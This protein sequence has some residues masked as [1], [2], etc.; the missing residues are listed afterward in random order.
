MTTNKDFKH[1][2]RAR[3]AKTGESYT[4]ARAVLLKRRHEG[5]RAGGQTASQSALVP[6]G[7]LAL[8]AGMSDAKVKQATGCDWSSW[9]KALDYAEA[10]NWPHGEIARYVKEKFK[11]P[12]WWTQTVTVGYER[13]KGLRQKGQRRDGG[14]EASKSVTLP[15]PVGKLYRAFNDKRARRGW[16]PGIDLAIRSKTRDKYMRIT[17]PD[18]TSVLVGFYAKGAGK[19][20]V[21]VQHVGLADQDAVLRSK[22]YWG[23]RFA[24]LKELLT[25]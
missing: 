11:T 14:F 22:G 23:E 19:S 1:L 13:I 15:V 17:W 7:P 12:D 9:A 25:H 6:S 2:V 3:M 16:L 24:T 4:S 5:K 21:A 10:Y 20:Q 18:K 8:L